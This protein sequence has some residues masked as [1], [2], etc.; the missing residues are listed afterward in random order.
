[1]K[2]LNFNILDENQDVTAYERHYTSSLLSTYQRRNSSPP[3]PHHGLSRNH[4]VRHPRT[5]GGTPHPNCVTSIHNRRGGTGILERQKNTL[6]ADTGESD[7]PPARKRILD[8]LE[9]EFDSG[10]TSN[11]FDTLG[12]DIMIATISWW[13]MHQTI[14]FCLNFACQLQMNN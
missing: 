5:T 4:V 2:R 9:S 13:Q 12:F 11:L 8:L 14:I 6:H 7:Q 10:S 3:F 1:M